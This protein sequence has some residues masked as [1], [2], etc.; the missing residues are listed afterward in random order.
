MSHDDLSNNYKKT[1][2]SI[3]RSICSST[4]HLK[5]IGI[6]Y[7]AIN[8][9]NVMNF[10]FIKQFPTSYPWQKLLMQREVAQFNLGN[11]QRNSIFDPKNATQKNALLTFIHLISKYFPD[12]KKIATLSSLTAIM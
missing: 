4:I 1:T 3:K 11:F 10:K 6:Y 9:N 8:F 7:G 2:P 5:H 12:T